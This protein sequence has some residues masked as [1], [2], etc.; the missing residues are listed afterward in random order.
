MK[1]PAL[2]VLCLAVI[3]ACTQPAAPP[4][5][6]RDWENPEVIGRNKEPAHA[7]YIPYAD[8]ESALV[9]DASV[10]P[11]YRSLNGAWKFNWVSRPAERPADFF[12]PAFDVGSWD[13]IEVPG[14]WELQGYGVPIY[15]DTGPIGALGTPP[16]VRDERNPVGSFRREFE[17]PA[18]W[19]GRR[20]FL[21]FEGV[22]SAFYVWVNGD[23]VGY[24]QGSRT[25]AEFDITSYVR[26]GNNTLAVEVYRWSDGS[27]LEDQDFWRLS[28]IDR[29]VYL[30]STPTVHI[31]DFFAHA[32]LD[33][34][35][36]DG[37]LDVTVSVRNSSPAA[38]PG[39][40]LHLDLLDAGGASVLRTPLGQDLDVPAAG[41]VALQLSQEIRTPLRWSAETPNLYTLLV[42]LLDESGAAVEVVA[43]KVGFRTVEIRDGML[44][45]NG[46]PVHLKGVNRHEHDPDRGHVVSEESMLADIRLMKQFNINAVRTAHYPNVPRWYE[47]CDEHGI[48]VVDEANVE[49]HGTGYHPDRTLAAKPEW[50]EAHLDRLVRMVERDKNHPSVIIWS[51]GNE[52]GDGDNFRAMYDWTRERD[53]SRPVQYEMADLREHTDIFAP[54]YARIHI[55]EAYASE[56][57][58]RPL[59]LCEYAHAMGNSV[60]NLKDYWDVIYANDQLQGGFI[61]DWV[62]QGIRVSSDDG[63][64]YFAYGGDFGPA[65]VPS[66]DNFCIN[67]LVSPDREANPHLWEVKKVYQNVDV[68]P[69]DLASGQVEIENRFDFTDLSDLELTWTVTGDGQVV[70]EG[71]LASLRLAPHQTRVVSLPLPSIDP[72]PGVE[73]FLDVRFHTRQAGTMV[74]EGHEVAAQQFGLPLYA[75]YTVAPEARAQKLLTSEEDGE[76]RIEG[77]GFNLSVDL[78]DGQ[79]TSWIYED[80][81]LV[82]TGPEPGFWR[83]P[84]DNDFGNEMPE[85]QGVWKEAGPERD[86]DEVSWYQNSNR[87]VH[88]DITATLPAGDS[89]LFTNYVIYGSGELVINNRFVPGAIDLPNLPRLGMHMTLPVGLDNV[90]WLGR[91]P[92]ENYQD[93][94]SGAPIGVY[95][96]TV[97]EQ[98]FPY[99]RPQEN[100]YK[101]D[102]RWVALTNDNGIGLLAAG[103]PTFS[104]SALHFLS[105]D[106]DPGPEK[107]QRHTID[108]IERDLV[109]LRLDYGQMG[110][111]GDTSWGARPHPQYSLPPQE[112]VYSILLK[113]FSSQNGPAAQQARHNFTR[114]SQ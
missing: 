53:P 79:I 42:S 33:S 84:T 58:D 6:L 43:T 13:D 5:E 73:Y 100:G 11:F 107:R 35:F 50:E 59:I 67:G 77:E 89:K 26:S 22:R 69:L 76:L 31:R 71:N 74:P 112:Y 34:A 44:Q 36:A 62:D 4:R 48:Y 105:E 55:L 111:G 3:G 98:Y 32:G 78:S 85:R 1:R 47:L 60:G 68:R 103:I 90:E 80:T 86:I 83:P 92:H 40:R 91:G 109:E 16:R 10:S 28:G 114:Q 8:R 17:V 52:A 9:G 70:A 51:L 23:E 37:A 108:L 88:V 93:R 110:V 63:D 102:V 104:F 113:P 101:T 57:R 38:A 39:G 64:E 56:P 82:L 41:E 27:Y 24:S 49:S 81:E 87:D 65:D 15:V 20:I 46:V 21:H 72:E 96:S 75:A 25:P 61:W 18:T 30:F 14:N 45:V 7:T 54:M 29:N 19:D 12:D 2:A 66:G 97:G 106:F 95:R 94:N 99:I